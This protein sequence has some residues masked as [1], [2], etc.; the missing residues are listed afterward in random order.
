L[1][2]SEQ[3]D[4][5]FIYFDWCVILMQSKNSIE[6]PSCRFIQDD[7]PDGPDHCSLHKI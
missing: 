4:G 2:E 1:E 5:I 6:T 7:Q 3:S